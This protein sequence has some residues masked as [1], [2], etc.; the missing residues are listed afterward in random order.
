[1][2]TGLEWQWYRGGS[3]D[4]NAIPEAECPA[5]QADNCLIKDATSA[6]YVPTTEGDAT[7][8]LTVVAIYTDGHANEDDAKDMVVARGGNDVLVST[9]NQAPV[10][11]DQ[12]E[13][14]EGRQTAQE[15][16]IAENSPAMTNGDPTTIGDP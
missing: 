2:R 14:T 16:S 6:T 15:R 3:F 11:P 13:E 7:N 8:R 9:V 12:D 10:F 4:E 5:T 1:M